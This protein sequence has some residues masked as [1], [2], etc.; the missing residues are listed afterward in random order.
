MSEPIH[1]RYT[2]NRENVQKLFESSY[3]YQFE[4][5]A[6]RYIGW[7]FIAILQFGVVAALKKGDFSLLLFSSIVLVYWYYG[8][9]IIARKRAERAFETSSFRDKTIFI[10][11]SDEGFEIKGKEGRVQWSWDEIDEIIVLDNAMMLYKYPYFHY[12]PDS[13]FHSIE[14]KSRFKKM[15]KA[16]HKMAE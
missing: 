12:I 11:V 8:K 5:S 7:L 1:I 4:N 2:W 15:A 13:G 14:D 6:K 9:K 16:H 10:D 3:K